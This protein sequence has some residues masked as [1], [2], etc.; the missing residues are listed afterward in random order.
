MNSEISE[1]LKHWDYYKLAKLTQE[2]NNGE[3]RTTQV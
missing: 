2:V 3:V 1:A